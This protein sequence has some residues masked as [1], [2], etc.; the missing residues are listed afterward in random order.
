MSVI[1]KYFGL[2]DPQYVSLG[3]NVIMSSRK[4]VALREAI[5]LL[6]GDDNVCSE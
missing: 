3:C 4:Y 2:V 5:D 1:A 6:S